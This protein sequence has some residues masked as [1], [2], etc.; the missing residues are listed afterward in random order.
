MQHLALLMAMLIAGVF[1]NTEKLIFQASD[2]HEISIFSLIA[3]QRVLA[4]LRP[5]FSQTRQAILPTTAKDNSS[6]FPHWYKLSDVKSGSSYELR[7]SYPAIT[8]TDFYMTLMDS[9]QLRDYLGSKGE[10]SHTEEDT[11]EPSYWLLVEAHWTG[12]SRQPGPRASPVIYDIG[13]PRPRSN[14][15]FGCD[16]NHVISS[17]DAV[18]WLFVL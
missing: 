10:S 9:C 18:F 17:R 6:S 16:F 13:K 3:D 5:P 11:R 2:M 1:A 4:E 15:E 14:A 12:V 7:I 8:P